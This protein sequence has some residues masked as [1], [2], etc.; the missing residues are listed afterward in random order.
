[1]DYLDRP[2]QK[3][4]PNAQMKI[5]FLGDSTAAGIGSA[6]PETSTAGWFSQNFPQASI[7]NISQSGLKLDGLLKKLPQI[8]QEKYTLT[9]IQIGAND[10]MKL[11]SL[12]KIDEEVRTLLKYLQPKTAYISIL[13]SGDI[14]TATIFIW[15]F[16]KIL[17]WRSHKV[18]DI[19]EKAAADY[20]ARYVD[21]IKNNIDQK[22][23]GDQSKY[24]AKDGLHLSSEGYYLWYEAI[25]KS[26][27]DT[28]FYL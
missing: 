3:I 10:I 5:L 11:T 12:R 25:R 26:L 15:P 28:P 14:G 23:S 7:T 20:G 2:F 13:H 1:M 27:K 24:Y 21:L 9:V 4:N 17:S 16:N 19:Y 18:H 8:P 6:S 22:L